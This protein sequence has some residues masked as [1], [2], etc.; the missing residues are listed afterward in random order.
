MADSAKQNET[1]SNGVRR[2][3]LNVDEQGVIAKKKDEPASIPAPVPDQSIKTNA[4]NRAHGTPVKPKR[5]NQPTKKPLTQLGLSQSK[6]LTLDD[7]RK[8]G[9]RIFKLKSYTTVGKINRKFAQEKQQRLLR[10]I[11]SFVLLAIILIVLF[12]IYNPFTDINDFRKMFGIDSPF[13]T[14]PSLPSI[15][16]T[17]LPTIH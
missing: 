16:T 3:H 15:E 13:M 1:N 11:F 4:P 9:A 10:N 6:Y 5:K 17:I 2:I 7:Q 14:M 8:L 12:V